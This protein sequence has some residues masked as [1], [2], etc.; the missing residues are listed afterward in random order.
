MFVA[1]KFGMPVLFSMQ[2]MVQANVTCIFNQHYMLH[3]VFLRVDM[4]YGNGAGVY[5]AVNVE[6]GLLFI[7]VRG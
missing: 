3:T 4:C 6:P 1:F 2:G 5:K 7:A